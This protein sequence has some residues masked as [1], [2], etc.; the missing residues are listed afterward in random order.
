MGIGNDMSLHW[1]DRSTLGV[2]V[3]VRNEYSDFDY[4]DK[5]SPEDLEFLKAFNRE[6][7]NADFKHVYKKLHKKKKD[8]KA[9]YSLNNS[10]NR[11]LYSLSKV[12]RR[13]QLGYEVC[14]NTI[15]KDNLP[16]HSNVDFGNM[17]YYWESESTRVPHG[18]L[19]KKGIR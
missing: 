7:Y 14:K 12:R 13:L 10:R 15:A 9:C 8:R 1:N 6:Y 4:V 17:D 5:L 19:L 3:K 2:S 11:D 16:R 18:T